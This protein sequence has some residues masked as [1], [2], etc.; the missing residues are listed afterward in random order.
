MPGMDKQG[1]GRAE[2]AKLSTPTASTDRLLSLL[3]AQVLSV[4]P[5]FQ[6]LLSQ[7]D[8]A[9]E[10]LDEANPRRGG[11]TSTWRAYYLVVS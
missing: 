2:C 8:E 1:G 7:L 9:D 6:R 11:V 3:A 4:F 10:Q 5:C